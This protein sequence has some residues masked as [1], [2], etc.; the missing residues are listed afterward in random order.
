[1]S[2]EEKQYVKKQKVVHFGSLDE[3][4][5]RS[6]SPEAQ[7]DNIQVIE[8]KLSNCLCYP[9]VVRQ[10]IVLLLRHVLDPHSGCRNN[11]KRILLTNIRRSLLA[12]G[13]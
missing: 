12:R 6:A 11:V 4:P 5:I 9:L 3:V 2:D 8:S 7:N 13:K 10:S 1:M